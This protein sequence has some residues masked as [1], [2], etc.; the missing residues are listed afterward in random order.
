MPKKIFQILIYLLQATSLFFVFRTILIN[1][2]ELS[3]L[4]LTGANTLLPIFGALAL[5][6]FV[7]FV[8]IR[9]Y[10]LLLE[11]FEGRSFTLH[12]IAN[13]YGRSALAK[14][15]PGNVF[16]IIG[17][18]VLGKEL[19]LSQVSVAASSF[20]EI[21]LHL[22]ASSLISLVFVLTGQTLLIPGLSEGLTLILLLAGT[23]GPLIFVFASGTIRLPIFQRVGL[24]AKLEFG[25]K[26]ILSA[27][28][29]YVMFILFSGIVFVYLRATMF[30]SIGISTVGAYLSAFS[31]SFLIGY[32]T[33]GAPGGIGVREAL[34][35]FFLSSISSPA[36]VAATALA[37]RISW[38][39][40]EL[41]FAYLVVPF[42]K[43][44]VESLA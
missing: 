27:G 39:T 14:Y 17:R 42:L 23:L 32:V 1:R 20:F 40:A 21:V 41:L 8:P 15:L 38:I 24:P 13:L 18:Q 25:R 16:H 30:G 26:N 35:V 12:S 37:H 31:L 36:I 3:Q 29:Y 33:P 10:K 7:I 2:D 11:S 19:G 6:C 22:F 5:F 34:L 44:R 9:G 43:K 28:S 4:N